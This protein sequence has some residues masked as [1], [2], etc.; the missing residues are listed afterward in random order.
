VAKT[1]NQQDA[2]ETLKGILMVQDKA[3]LATE[4]AEL[5]VKHVRLGN[6]PNVLHYSALNMDVIHDAN[7]FVIKIGDET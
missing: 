4:L 6:A 5:I 7:Q 2:V 1:Y 3:F